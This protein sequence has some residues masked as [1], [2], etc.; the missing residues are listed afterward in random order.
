MTKRTQVTIH[1]PLDVFNF[2]DKHY[3][4]FSF[5]TRAEFI[6]EVLRGF[7]VDNRGLK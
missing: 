4:R 2:Y 6:R 3:E 1:I 5:V 7:Y